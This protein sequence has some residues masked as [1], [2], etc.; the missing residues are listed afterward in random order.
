[1]QPD[2]LQSYV[3]FMREHLFDHVDIPPGNWHVPD[4]TLPIEQVDDYCRWYEEQIAQGG[5]HRHSDSWASAAPGTSASTSR[6]RASESRTRLITLDRV[7]RI[8]AASDFFGEEHVP[9]R[10]ITMGVGTILDARQVIMLAF[11]EHKAPIIAKAVEGEITLDRSRPASCSSIPNAQVVLDE[12]AADGAHALPNRR[13]CSGRVEW[14]EVSDPQGGD[15]AGPQARRSRSSSSPTRTTTKKACRICSPSTGRRTTSTSR[16][17]AT[18]RRRSPAGPAASR[19]MPSSRATARGRTTTSFPKR[20]LDLLAASGRRRDLDG[21]HAHP[22]GRSGARSARRL[23]DVRQHRRVRRRCDPLRRLRRRVQHALRRIAAD[24]RPSSKRTSKSSCSN[25]KPG[26]VDS[27]EVQTIKGM[28]RRGEARA[29]DAQLRRARRAAA[30]PGHAV[31][32][33]RPREEEAA[34]RRR[35]RR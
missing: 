24:G 15:L 9:R 22:P 10:A 1:M 7:T 16:S 33:N 12:A 8:D 14:D 32:R 35:H 4:G 11:G 23:S 17:S 27:P 13:G 31:L 20:V 29:A 34:R 6:A 21:R 30:L 3:R 28:I 5:R 2:E 26:Q 25:K 18:C 19:R